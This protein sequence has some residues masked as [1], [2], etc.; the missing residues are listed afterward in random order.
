MHGTYSPAVE[1]SEMR[2]WH[3][4][5]LV[6]EAVGVPPAFVSLFFSVS[7]HS[8]ASIH[9]DVSFD[10]ACFLGCCNCFLLDSRTS[11]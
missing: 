5:S 2:M 8:G 7:A 10:T 11:S 3:Y 1:R 4:I 9:H 6:S